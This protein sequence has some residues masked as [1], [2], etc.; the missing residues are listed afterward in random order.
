MR[1][2]FKQMLDRRITRDVEVA[3]RGMWQVG[4]VPDQLADG[5]FEYENDLEARFTFD[6][7]NCRC[8]TGLK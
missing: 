1:G 8:Y 3:F 4:W 6:E 2:C 5:A 7:S